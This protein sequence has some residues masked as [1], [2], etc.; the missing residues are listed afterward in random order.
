MATLEFG[1]YLS[2]GSSN[3]D[4][5]LSLGGE[6][7][8]TA[9]EILP[10]NN[11]FSDITGTQSSEGNVDYR[12]FYITNDTGYD[13]SDVVVYIFSEVA[14]GATVAL[15]VPVQNEI[16][17]LKFLDNPQGGTF[18]L[19]LDGSTTSNISF[20]FNNTTLASNIQ[21]ALRTL[22]AGEECTVA[23]SISEDAFLVEFGGVQ[24]AHRLPLITLADNQL[25]YS[26]PP[27]PTIYITLIQVGSPV[28]STAIDIG[29]DTI[30]PSGVNF[31]TEPI[32]IGRVK[33]TELFPVWVQRT[34]APDSEPQNEDGFELGIVGDINLI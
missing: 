30:A 25:T 15:G 28:N 4:P 2:G 33:D 32:S 29:N 21:T 3:Q 6:P 8:I 14:N 11:L 34:I 9:V 5:N 7:S 20:S 12:C 17:S 22:P 1:L 24:S 26:S 13:Y 16:Q 27:I 18:K 23:Y 19:E 10:E 31:S